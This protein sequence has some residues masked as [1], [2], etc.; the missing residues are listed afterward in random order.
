MI[1]V[2]VNE[3]VCWNSSAHMCVCHGTADM[4]MKSEEPQVHYGLWPGY[5]RT[6][7]S[8]LNPREPRLK[9]QQVQKKN[10]GRGIT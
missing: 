3:D 9:Q 10:T 7:S 5:R 4:C 8:W 6:G 2:A 1:A